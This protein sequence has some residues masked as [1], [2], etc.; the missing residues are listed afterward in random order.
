MTARKRWISIAGK[1]NLALFGKLKAAIHRTLGLRKNRAICRSS[2][3]SYRSAASV[4]QYKIN[5]V[6]LGPLCKS[7]LSGMEYQGGRRWAGVF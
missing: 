2:S 4:H 1:D 6:L 5:V 3:T 7:G